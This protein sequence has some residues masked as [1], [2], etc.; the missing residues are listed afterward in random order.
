LDAQ[1]ETSQVA[2]FA[3][4][5][6]K[7]IDHAIGDARHYRLKLP[8]A[9]L[10]E[11]RIEQPVILLIGETGSSWSGRP[12]FVRLFSCREKA[13]EALVAFVDNNW[14]PE[15]LEMPMPEDRDE[16]IEYYFANVM[17]RYEYIDAPESMEEDED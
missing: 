7:H 16:R 10:G 1:I 8:R 13:E 14:E 15:G 11:L 9:T 2:G 6:H 17:E 5:L 4:S 3:G 12:P